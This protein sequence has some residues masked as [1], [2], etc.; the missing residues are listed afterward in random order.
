M[1]LTITIG[2]WV[3]NCPICGSLLTQEN[4]KRQVIKTCQSDPAHHFLVKNHI[5][6]SHKGG[7]VYKLGVVLVV[8][9]VITFVVVA[10]LRAPVGLLLLPAGALVVWLIIQII[11]AEKAKHDF[12]KKYPALRQKP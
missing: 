11:I 4:I 7:N 3:V 9:S 8:L 5:T 1:K 2:D 12:N 10:F 6:H